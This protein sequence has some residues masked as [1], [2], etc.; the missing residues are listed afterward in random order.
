MQKRAL[1]KTGYDVGAIVYGGIVSMNDGQEASDRY[2]AWSIDHGVNYYD[3]AP[4]YGDAEEKLGRSLIPYPKDI[5]LA[6]K[7]TQ[8]L[9]ADAEKELKRSLELLHTDH[10]DVYQLHSMTTQ[11]DI[12]KAFGK[13]GIMEMVVKLKQ[14]GVLRKVGF[15]AHSEQAALKLLEMY[16]F[17]TVLFSMN[18]ML[19]KN[20]G[21]GRA[22][23]KKAQEKGFGLLGMKSLIERA[24]K[25]DDEKAASPYTKSWCKPFDVSQKELRVAAMKYSI[26]MGSDVLVSPGNFEN[27]SFMVEH[28]DEV[29]KPLTDDERRLLDAHF[30]NV[31]AYP[32]FVKTN[33]GWA[34]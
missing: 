17:D 24:W 8:R 14:E 9:K 10:F 33:G 12:D 11:D 28:A 2:V 25:N 34:A 4:T 15:S 3:V 27:F 19:D 22:L 16:D 30:K 13:G 18:W 6:C 7:T 29:L 5:L 31:A 1:G 32:F 23:A 20:E 26:E 21:I